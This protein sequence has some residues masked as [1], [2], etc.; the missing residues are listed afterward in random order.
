VEQD[1][2]E[3]FMAHVTGAARSITKIKARGMSSYN[4]GSTHTACLRVLFKSKNGLTRTQLTK[5]CELDKSQ[6]SRVIN[7]LEEKG[8]VTETSE[9]TGYKRKISLTPEGIQI[10]E[11]INRLVIAINDSVSGEISP[12]EI[13]TFYRVFGKI[14]TN[15]KHAEGYFDAN[16]TATAANK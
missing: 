11:E 9:T 13:E 10:T 1:R 2:L 7:E 8:Y 4:L 14:C 3:T 16:G 6:I 5:K 15:L 12:E